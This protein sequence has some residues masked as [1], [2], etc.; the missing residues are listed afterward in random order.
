MFDSEIYS[1]RFWEIDFARGIALIMMLISNF[2]TDLQF[3]LDYSE[4]KLFWRIFA[5]ATA[6]LFVS[7]SGL[8]LWI[9]HARGKKNIRKYLQRFTKLFGLGLL[10]TLSTYIL[11][12]R[13]TIYFGV[14]HFLGVASLLVIPFYQLGWKNIFIAP[15]FL[16]G[17][18]IVREIHAESLFLLPLG[19]TP[20]QF[21]TLDY[22]PIFPWFGVFLLGTAVGG[23]LYPHGQRKFNLNNLDNPV[24]DVICFIGRN[25][26]KIYLIHQPVFVG[27]LM[28]IY[29]GLPNL[30]V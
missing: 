22:F 1:K 23:I 3:F 20:H 18:E 29:G 9:S 7:I 15:L 26:L 24:I 5:Y 17:H 6:S 12:K 19:I 28:L 27:L 13:G 10:I 8:S 25:T 11:L 2:V 30:G 21:F 16:L 14:L 4:H